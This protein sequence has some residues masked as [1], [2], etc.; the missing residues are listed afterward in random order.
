MP[1]AVR[2]EAPASVVSA[3]LAAYPEAAGRALNDGNLPLHLCLEGKASLEVVELLAHAFPQAL[4]AKTNAGRT[5][6]WS[7]ARF[8]APLAVVEFLPVI[9]PGRR[10]AQFMIDLEEMV[11][12]ASNRLMAEAGFE[13]EE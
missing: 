4:S 2:Y 8:K 3:L 6:L 7:A 13:G 1:A 10:T 12:T 11:E 9:E 5:P